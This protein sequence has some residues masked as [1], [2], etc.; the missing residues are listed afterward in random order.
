MYIT[1]EESIAKIAESSGVDWIFIDLELNGKEE[2]QGH[3]DTVI[4]RHSIDDVRKIKKVLN[5][6]E[7][8][9]RVNPIFDCSELEIHKV[10][11]DGAD[12]VMLPFFK[13]KDEVKTFINYVD[14][15]AKTCLL[16]ETAEAVEQIDDILELKG[17]DL[18]HIGLNDLHLSYK[19]N[20]MF[21]LLTNGTVEMLCNKFKAKSILY[22]FGGMAR[23]GQGDLP[24]ELILGEHYRLGS[25]MVILSRSFCDVNKCVDFERIE[26]FFKTGITDIRKYEKSLLN[27]N[28]IFF[29]GNNELIY[30][31]V[32]KIVNKNKQS[33]VSMGKLK[34]IT[35]NLLIANKLP[36]EQAEIVADCIVE[37]DVCGVNT[38]GV[39][40]LP[41]HI[42]RLRGGGYN[43]SPNF[44]V[45][46]ENVSF[47]VIDS[48]NS[49]GFFSAVHCMKYAMEACRQTGIFTVFSRNSNT[50]GSAFYYPLLAASEGLIAITYCNSPAA[51]APWGGKEKMV[52]TNPFS[53]AIPCKNS[54]PIILDMATSKVAKSK[55][56]KAK[57]ENEK[58]PLGFALDEEG[59]PT[60]DPIAA[61]RGLLLPMEGHKGYG[62]ALAIDILA[63]VLSGASFLNNVGKFYSGNNN[64]MNVGQTFI[65]IDPIQIYGE[66]F[67]ECMDEYVKVVHDSKS[68]TTEKVRLPG[69]NKFRNKKNN[70][71]LGI[72]LHKTTV[73][74]LNICLSESG[75]KERIEVKK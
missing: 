21:E 8:L 55:I 22:G 64:G 23:L 25:S 14:G 62:I 60:T 61:I 17:I 37:S 9:V 44:K 10:I 32:C 48:D 47:A 65:A 53:I 7:L 73:D 46:R 36:N 1:N 56:N 16:L 51:M 2:R 35:Y 6:A 57:L 63:G 42:R 19:M 70:L 24:A 30:K 15:K 27:M 41:A 33:T 31:K 18:I 43:I 69:D 28:P 71:K 74:K 34:T 40:V 49:I 20:F 12:I 3:L 5:K 68:L 38:H 50:Y 39:A 67:Y 13:T 59:I 29:E 4:S 52:G 11:E 72:G 66:S 58:I 26:N 45:L 54:D 75:L